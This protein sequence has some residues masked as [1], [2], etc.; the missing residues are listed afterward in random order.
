[1]GRKNKTQQSKHGVWNKNIVIDKEMKIDNWGLSYFR[2]QSFS[3]VGPW[4]V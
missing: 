2:E 3:V 4:R 1:M